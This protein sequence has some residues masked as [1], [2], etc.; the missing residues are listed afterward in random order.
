M[1]YNVRD[2]EY[3]MFVTH[4]VP[5][6]WNLL[7]LSFETFT[8]YFQDSQD[9]LYIKTFRTSEDFRYTVFKMQQSRF[10]TCNNCKSS[11]FMTYRLGILN[12]S[13]FS[14]P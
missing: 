14:P 7:K 1:E 5:R 11:V 8:A 12:D 13:N 2:C 3:N 6:L 4:R 9:L 10:K